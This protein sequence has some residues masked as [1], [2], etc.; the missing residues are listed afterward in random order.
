MLLI[1]LWELKNL[2]SFSRPASSSQHG[3]RPGDRGAFPPQPRQELQGAR[4]RR[5]QLGVHHGLGG[6]PLRQGA[7]RDLAADQKQGESLVIRQQPKLLPRQPHGQPQ[8]LPLRGLLK[9]RGIFLF[10]E[11]IA[12]PQCPPHPHALPIMPAPTS[13][14]LSA[15]VCHQHPRGNACLLVC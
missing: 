1:S 7:G 3:L 11:G 5:H 13:T 12:P 14:P 15:L 6:R 8:P 10:L 9:G 4:A 2:P